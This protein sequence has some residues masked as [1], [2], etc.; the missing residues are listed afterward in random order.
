MDRAIALGKEM[1]LYHRF[2]Y[3]NYAGA[4]RDVFS[5]YGPENH[6]RLKRIQQKYDPEG[7]FARLQP[8]YFK[9]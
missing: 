3:Q 1:K 8:G 7:V 9:L 4:G 2:I 6:E 5:G